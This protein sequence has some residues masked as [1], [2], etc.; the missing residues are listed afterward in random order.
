[1]LRIKILS[2]GDI[3]TKTNVSGKPY[4]QFSLDYKVGDKAA[5]RKILS[6][7]ETYKFFKDAEVGST[8]DIDDVKE[9]AYY[10]WKS[11]SKVDVSK[12]SN[13]VSSAPS[14]PVQDTVTLRTGTFTNKSTYETAEE[15]AF[16]QVCIVRQTCVERALDFYNAD[17]TRTVGDVIQI[18]KQFEAYVFQT[19]E[20][21]LAEEEFVDST[22]EVYG[23]GI[24]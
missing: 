16:K 12:E 11:A 14:I 7:S 2:K 21:R 5:T 1:M 17:D 13:V 24:K 20:S 22:E 9:G 3:E 18:A 15:R 6:Y 23:N 10:Q 19:K 4:T 8:Y